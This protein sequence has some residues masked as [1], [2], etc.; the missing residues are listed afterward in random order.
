M[1]KQ[2]RLAELAAPA[3]GLPPPLPGFEHINRYW[4][5]TR[6]RIAAKLLPGE[7][8]VTRADEVLV[9]VLGS[10]VAAC[11]RDPLAKV[12]GMNHF[13]LP[14][15][16]REARAAQVGAR[17]AA[18]YG[19]EAMRSLIEAVLAAGGRRERLEVK[20][21]GG[22]RILSQ[23]TD[24]G[25]S[26]IEFALRYVQD[27]GLKL[28]AADLGDVYPRKVYFEPQTGRVQV[29]KLRALRNETVVAREQSY[30]ERLASNALPQ[31]R[32]K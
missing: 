11:I 13:M 32:E 24:I 31:R 18:H 6:G 19:E 5:P 9:T 1:K 26:N 23:M 20:L 10:C 27:Q 4:D 2:D 14:V 16:G 28:I 7:Y 12:G 29:Y 30:L 17:E 15:M 25:Q 22:G 21:F 8:Y 3:A